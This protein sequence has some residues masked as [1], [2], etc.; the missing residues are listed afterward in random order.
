MPNEKRGA[1]SLEKELRELRERAK[2]YSG[3]MEDPDLRSFRNYAHVALQD[4]LLA[5]ERAL[6]RTDFHMTETFMSST[7][8]ARLASEIL[9][10]QPCYRTPEAAKRGAALSGRTSYLVRI[11]IEPLTRGRPLS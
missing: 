6:A 5:A 10:N 4:A 2:D 7:S 8:G 9:A 11:I 3:V 1:L